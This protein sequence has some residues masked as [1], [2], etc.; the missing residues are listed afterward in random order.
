MSIDQSVSV[1][2]IPNAIPMQPMHASIP[3]PM[4]NNVPHLAHPG[5]GGGYPVAYGYGMVPMHQLPQHQIPQQHHIPP[6]QQQHQIPQQQHQLPPQQQQQQ[7][8]MQ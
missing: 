2:V 6:Q 1:P 4:M 3:M 7:G 5:H 8:F